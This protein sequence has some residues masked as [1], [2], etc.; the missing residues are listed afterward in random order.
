MIIHVLNGDAL[1]Q[2]F[3][4]DDKVIVFRECLIDGPV[5]A[6]DEDKFWQARRG[7]IVTVFDTTADQYDEHVLRELEK[8]GSLRPNDEI[9]FWF[10]RD[11]FCQTNLWFMIHYVNRLHIALQYS[12]AYPDFQI[13]QN[14]RG[15]GY[16][17]A[18]HL[19]N[20][21]QNRIALSVNDIRL[22]STLWEAYASHDRSKLIAL[23]KEKSIAFPSLA[24]VISAHLDR[25]P[26]TGLGRPM[27]KLRQLQLNGFKSF[28]EI[29]T[30]F[31]ETEGVYGFGD[32][33]V[34]QM[35]DEITQSSK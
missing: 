21:F 27:E 31:S 3:P 23:A 4:L 22:G 26:S 29:F 11:L 12:I 33:Q 10:E 17:T 6:R 28:H 1:A 19:N 2:K 7:Y 5:D 35:L 13:D 32:L 30:S 20:C 24:E 15:F 8:L 34:K 25:F 14:W 9:C 18:D 16:H